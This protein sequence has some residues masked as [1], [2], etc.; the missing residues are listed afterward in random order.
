MLARWLEAI[1]R[2][3][4]DESLADSILGDLKESC[5]APRQTHG[6]VWYYRE[7]LAII[8]RA[9]AER[10]GRAFSH[11]SFGSHVRG[12][13]GDIRVEFRSLGSRPWYAGTGMRVICL[14]VA[15]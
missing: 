1:L 15:R 12:S 3:A 7:L 10:I 6:L 11:S 5:R 14:T 9:V 2:L 4:T 13:Q 8:A